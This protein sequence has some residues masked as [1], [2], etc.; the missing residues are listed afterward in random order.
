MKIC[1][2]YYI[3]LS[4]ESRS[5]EQAW[6]IVNPKLSSKFKKKKKKTASKLFLLFVWEIPTLLC[7][8]FCSPKCRWH[9]R[10]VEEV[11]DWWSKRRRIRRSVAETLVPWAREVLRRGR[12]R[13]RPWERAWTSWIP[14]GSVTWIQSEPEA[15]PNSEVHVG[16]R[17]CRSRKV[18]ET[19]KVLPVAVLYHMHH[20]KPLVVSV[21]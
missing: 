14:E 1:I 7:R 6:V 8:A 10:R 21:Y 18:L 20:N 2:E 4:R 3:K 17:H 11:S 16:W 19:K 12:V 13:A 5:V 9:H 15:L